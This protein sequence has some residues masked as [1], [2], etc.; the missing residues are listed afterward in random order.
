[1]HPLGIILHRFK[2]YRGVL[3]LHIFKLFSKCLNSTLA[4]LLMIAD[5]GDT[6]ATG[7]LT[8]I[9]HK[10][11]QHTTNHQICIHHQL[12]TS[13]LR[14]PRPL[15][16][17]LRNPLRDPLRNPILNRLRNP[18]LRYLLRPHPRAVTAISL[19]PTTFN[20]CL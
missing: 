2:W 12:F 19:Y 5:N 16:N 6:L 17:P 9:L 20:P 10:R 4:A 1:M 14:E 3:K 11:A 15:L 18:L 13:S 7:T 8:S